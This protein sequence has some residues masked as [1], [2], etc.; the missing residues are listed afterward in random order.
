MT[1]IQYNRL[2]D[3][4][5]DEIDAAIWT[6]DM[7]HDRENIAAFRDIMDRWEKG[8]KE[9]EGILTELEKENA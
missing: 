6:G 1:T 3:G 9:A 8:L 5:I 7:F 2:A 4:A